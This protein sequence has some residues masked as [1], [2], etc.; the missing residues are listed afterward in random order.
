VRE[1]KKLWKSK[2]NK[3]LWKFENRKPQKCLPT[4]KAISVKKLNSERPTL[5]LLQALRIEL[6]SSKPDARKL[7]AP[8]NG[9]RQLVAIP[10]NQSPFFQFF[11]HHLRCTFEPVYARFNNSRVDRD[12]QPRFLPS[13]EKE[14]GEVTV[15]KRRTIHAPYENT[16]V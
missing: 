15:H 6:P 8:Q 14:G 7:E 3:K 4:G 16:K 2:I 9:Q 1:E 12:F 10:G 11:S 13:P 5:S